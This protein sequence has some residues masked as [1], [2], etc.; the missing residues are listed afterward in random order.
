MGIKKIEKIEI[1]FNNSRYMSSD[2]E[3]QEQVR[4]D[5]LKSVSDIFS[6]KIYNLFKFFK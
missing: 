4:Y 5:F 1:S 2:A 3:S 6:S